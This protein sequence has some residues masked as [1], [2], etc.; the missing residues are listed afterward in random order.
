MSTCEFGL[1]T[2]LHPTA[3]TVSSRHLLPF[4]NAQTVP[5]RYINKMSHIVHIVAAKLVRHSGSPLA[6][7]VCNQVLQIPPPNNPQKSVP[8]CQV[9]KSDDYI[10]SWVECALT[11]RYADTR[12]LSILEDM[13]CTTYPMIRTLRAMT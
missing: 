3:R 2:R 13:C 4:L 6:F 8:Q 12:P 1:Y 9:I 7:A 5:K 11:L 10:R